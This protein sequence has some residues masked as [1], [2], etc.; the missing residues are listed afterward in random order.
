[1]FYD[2]YLKICEERGVA[3]A[4]I[5]AILGHED[6]STTLGYTHISL[7]EKLAGVNKQYVPSSSSE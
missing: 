4:V 6:Y 2:N 1:M 5:T 7:D 3:P